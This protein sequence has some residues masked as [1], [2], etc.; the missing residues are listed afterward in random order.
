VK[1]AHTDNDA[2]RV[3]QILTGSD[4]RWTFVG[5]ERLSRFAS[6]GQMNAPLLH[7]WNFAAAAAV[8][9]TSGRME[10]LIR[11]AVGVHLASLTSESES[12]NWVFNLPLDSNE[13][14]TLHWAQRHVAD[15]GN[16][17]ELASRV[18][19]HVPLGFWLQ[20]VTNRY[21]TRLWVPGLARA[22]PNLPGAA[23]MRR[24]TL[25]QLL[26]QAVDLRNLAAHLHPLFS[27]EAPQVLEPF[28]SVAQAIHP[29]AAAWI[30]ESSQIGEIW[31]SRPTEQV[32]EI[33]E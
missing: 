31:L 7:E 11:R 26:R 29:S 28:H 25:H 8:L 19:E 16:S 33:S 12:G 21:H 6:N 2:Q 15:N 1:V 5:A 4:D 30:S 3:I 9:A 24:E 13:L 20:L 27:L 18:L 32:E 23:T 22:F 10:V 17:L 14:R